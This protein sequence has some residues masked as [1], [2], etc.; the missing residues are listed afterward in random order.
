VKNI[1][2]SAKLLTDPQIKIMTEYENLPAKLAAQGLT[3]TAEKRSSL[4]G[5][6]MAAIL[7]NTQLALTKENDTFANLTPEQEQK[8]LPVLTRIFDSAFRKGYCKFKEAARF[9]LDAIKAKFGAEISDQISLQQLQGAYI[10]MAG[11]YKDEGADKSRDVVAVVSKKELE[12]SNLTGLEIYRD[13]LKIAGAFMESGICSYD[14]YRNVMVGEMGVAIKPYLRGIYEAFRHYPGFDSSQMTPASE[15]DALVGLCKLA[16]FE[17]AATLWQRGEM[18]SN[19][20]VDRGPLG[21]GEV[22]YEQNDEKAEYWFRKSAETG[23]CYFQWQFGEL[24]SEGCG[25]TQNLEQ[26][27]YWYS[28]AA[29]P[30]NWYLQ[31]KL[32]PSK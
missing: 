7:S 6:G 20:F 16:E 21:T 18:Y 22:V 2:F 1:I 3:A 12:E 14:A 11:R 15:I 32:V 23:D 5:R 10:G 8:L 9:V 26:A 31:N 29:E 28:K 27:A 17:D 30:G 19:G 24:Y 13:G 25:V 4:V